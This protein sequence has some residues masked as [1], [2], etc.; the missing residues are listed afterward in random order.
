M[1]GLDF[2][3]SGYYDSLTRGT[4][5]SVSGLYQKLIEGLDC[6][7]TPSYHAD[8]EE[9]QGCR[10]SGGGAGIEDFLKFE[11]CLQFIRHDVHPWT[12][13]RIDGLTITLSCELVPFDRKL[14]TKQQMKNELIVG[15][16]NRR[17]NL[18]GE[19]S[20]E[21]GKCLQ[22]EKKKIAQ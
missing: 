14:G 21:S 20:S 19:N 12:S 6:Q 18:V 4:T 13:L 2:F 5:T 8:L 7:L 9:D 1:L 22:Q 15:I 11:I 16:Q 10:D 17:K 3:V